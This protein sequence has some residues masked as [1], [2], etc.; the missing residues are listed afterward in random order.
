MQT[1]VQT[2]FMSAIRKLTAI[3]AFTLIALL[4]ISTSIFGADPIKLEA[5]AAQ[6]VTLNGVQIVQDQPGYS[7]TG[8]AWGFDDDSNGAITWFSPFQLRLEVISSPLGITHLTAIKDPGDCQR[9]QQR[10]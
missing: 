3:H 10:T 9:C 2:H 8:Y 4:S 7:G 1:P 6:G 5:E